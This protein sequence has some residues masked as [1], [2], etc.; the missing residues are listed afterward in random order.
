MDRE[1]SAY[2]QEED[3]GEKKK[4][5]EDRTPI[6]DLSKSDPPITTEISSV[7]NE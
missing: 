2:S 5:D 6:G 1:P 3:K 7:P 4:I